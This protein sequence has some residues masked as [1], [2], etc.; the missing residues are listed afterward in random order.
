MQIGKKWLFSLLE[1]T[2]TSPFNVRS[3]IKSF[4]ALCKYNEVAVSLNA[5]TAEAALMT[6]RFSS[7]ERQ[8]IL[9]VNGE[10]LGSERVN[11]N[12]VC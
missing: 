12:N 1:K 9:L 8:T 2:S 7:V 10:P 5:L 6:H 11:A 3:F 4:Y